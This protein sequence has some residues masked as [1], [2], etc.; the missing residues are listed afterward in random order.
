ME[1]SAADR[2]DRIESPPE[3]LW[4]RLRAEPHRAPEHIAL[5][6][7]D[8]FADPAADWAAGMRPRYEPPRLARHTVAKHRRLARIEG[9]ALGI[10][11]WITSAPDFVALAWLQCRM[12]FYVGAAYGFDPHDP[13]RP[14]ELLFLTG[15]Y[16]SAMEAR[17]SLDGVGRSMAAHY[18]G[19]KTSGNA[20]DRSLFA[21]LARFSGV[22]F[23]KRG[24]IKMIPFVASPINSF[25]NA[26]ATDRLGKTA[27]RYYG[28]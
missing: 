1:S 24:A 22:Y 16:P 28:G 19:Q 8:R 11:G 27:I 26:R 3:G 17:E 2:D 10:G 4:D 5:A 20:D 25:A 12:V 7:L 9:A 6:A 18:V 23:A 21:E 13:M 15:I 14:A